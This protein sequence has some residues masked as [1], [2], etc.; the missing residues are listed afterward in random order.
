M[1]VVRYI[2]VSG[3]SYHIHESCMHVII[4]MLLYFSGPWCGRRSGL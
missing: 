1:N 3:I 4:K 2:I